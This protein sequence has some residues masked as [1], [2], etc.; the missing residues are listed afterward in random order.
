MV[1][2]EQK[3]ADLVSKDPNVDSLMASVGGTTASNL[4]GPTMGTGGAPE[5]AQ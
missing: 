3:I 2:Y 1:D 4:G 5:A